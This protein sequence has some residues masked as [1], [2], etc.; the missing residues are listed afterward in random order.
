MQPSVRS[1]NALDG[2][3]LLPPMFITLSEVAYIISFLFFSVL[4]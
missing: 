2:I 1:E 4:I 3:S